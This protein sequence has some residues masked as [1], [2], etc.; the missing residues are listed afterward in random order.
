MSS[1]TSV[2]ELL[3]RI[4][5]LEKEIEKLK[6]KNE[7]ESKEIDISIAREEVK[8]QSSIIKKGG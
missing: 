2:D 7:A 3:I 6:E 4:Q 5:K 1:A 8:H